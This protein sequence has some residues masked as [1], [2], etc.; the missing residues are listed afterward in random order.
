[1]SIPNQ[2]FGLLA[3]SVSAV[4]IRRGLDPKVPSMPMILCWEA[5]VR[6]ESPAEKEPLSA[7]VS[8]PLLY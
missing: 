2:S 1:M 4:K 8:A 7:T 5:V 6:E 3:A